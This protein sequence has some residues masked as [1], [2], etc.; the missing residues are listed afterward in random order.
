MSGPA[1]GSEPLDL[2][3]GQALP[4]WRQ[5][6]ITQQQLVEWCAAENDYNPIHFEEGRA[7]AIGLP[8]R[9]IQGTFRF[10]LLAQYLRRYLPGWRLE[11]I[12]CRY[13][14]LALVGDTLEMSGSVTM[15]EGG[16]LVLAL[17][18]RNQSGILVATGEAEL[19]AS[20]RE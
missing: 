20:A 17:H 15:R 19:V 14:G 2:T 11:R 4:I 13:A 8:G 16:R 18:S 7:H 3:P 6:P 12:A 1:P 5:G 10:A 9:P